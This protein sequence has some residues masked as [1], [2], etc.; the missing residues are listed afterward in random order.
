MAKKIGVL[1]SGGDAPGMNAAVRAVCRA[2]L[3]KGMEVVGILRGYKAQA[4]K[5]G[6]FIPWVEINRGKT[7]KFTRTIG[8]QPRVERG[9][10]YIEENIPNLEWAI[11]EMIT[12]PK[13][14]HDDILDTFVDLENIYYAASDS[15]V[16]QES[17]DPNTF[18]GY[19]GKLE[20]ATFEESEEQDFLSVEGL[21]A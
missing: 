16:I 15:H 3:A 20:N 18:D 9:D 13:G 1:T 11:E 21:F 2:G 12:F 10:F 8:L 19:F 14:V 17:V 7:S 6:W 5:N 4:N